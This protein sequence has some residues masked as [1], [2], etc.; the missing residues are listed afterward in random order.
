MPAPRKFSEEIEN[1]ILEEF[2]SNLSSKQV[3]AKY[4]CYFNRTIKPRWLRAYGEKALQCIDGVPELAGLRKVQRLSREGVGKA[5]R[6]PK[7]VPSIR[8]MI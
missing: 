2:Y 1:K 6:L 4:G 3:A 5:G 8:T 7:R